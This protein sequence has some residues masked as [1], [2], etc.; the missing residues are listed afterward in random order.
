MD[1]LWYLSS[2]EL[3]DYLTEEEMNE[4]AEETTMSTL[5]AGT[6][7]QTPYG[8][9]D[10]LYFIKKGK[11]RMYTLSEDGKQF[12][13]GIIGNGAVYGDTEFF[14]LGTKDYYIETLDEIIIC[15]FP[16]K[17]FEAF[18]LAHPKMVMNLMKSLSQKIEEQNQ[19]LKQLA[20]YD[21]KQRLVYWLC[22]LANTF[23]NEEGDYI[24]IDLNL[25]HQEL[26]NMIGST[27]E[28]VS[29][30]LK[31]LAKLGIIIS[32]RLKISVSKSYLE[33]VDLNEL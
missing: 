19:M 26:A 6:V 29:L 31:E 20:L 23:G 4:V 24:S 13:N 15:T 9:P 28:S 14:S 30:T 17:T 1:K 27:R 2:I 3:F 16:S 21:I 8:S 33:G 32:G 25:S 5:P 7:V 18:L 10:G 12:T 22:K 11:L